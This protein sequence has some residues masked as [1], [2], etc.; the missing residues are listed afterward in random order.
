MMVLQLMN[1]MRSCVIW[2]YH[3]H[4]K[5]PSA[6][7]ILVNTDGKRAR[8]LRLRTIMPE[9]PTGLGLVHIHSGT[10]INYV[11]WREKAQ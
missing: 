1:G 11:T 10:I 2:S 8:S 5:L 7:R 6:L 3:E 9:V 4:G